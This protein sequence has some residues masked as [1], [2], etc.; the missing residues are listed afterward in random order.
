[1]EKELELR[2]YFFTNYQLTGIQKG[3]QCG[4]AAIEYA[5]KYG[6]VKLFKEF[7]KKWKTWIILDGG[8]TN[9]KRDLDGIVFGTLDQIGDTLLENDIRFAYF[10]EPD[11]NDALTAICFIADERVFNKEDFPDFLDWILN[12]KMYPQAR[13]EM[14]AQ[15]V[16]MLRMQS[17]EKLIEMFPE[18]YPE[19][20]KWIG[21]KE[22]VFLRELLK[23]KRL[24]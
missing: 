17:M 5:R 8:T 9:S 12:I 4:H 2:M 6:H 23:D 15:N 19:W 1:M 20:V 7:I 13:D 10:Q 22:N 16:V 14:P 24:A 3:I 18:W 11:L 21:G